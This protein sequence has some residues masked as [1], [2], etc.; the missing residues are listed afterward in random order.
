MPNLRSTLSDLASNFADAVLH[1]IRSASIADLHAG[2]EPVSRAR[3]GRA[4]GGRGSNGGD[5]HVVGRE[6]SA[7]ATK[8]KS[9]GKGRLGRR[10]PEEIA[11]TLDRVVGVLKATRGKGL[12]S[13]EIQKALKLDRREMP[14]VLG[15]GLSKKKLK[16]KGKRRSTTYFVA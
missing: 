1:A 10:T 16:S 3:R 15:E 11:K 6:S 13:E 12:R 7:P 8:G 14:R 5:A 2:G 4:G 9:A